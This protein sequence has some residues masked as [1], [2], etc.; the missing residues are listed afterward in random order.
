ME[1]VD[2]QGE[3]LHLAVAVIRKVSNW[4]PGKESPELVT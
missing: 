4:S 3:L 1:I 2:A